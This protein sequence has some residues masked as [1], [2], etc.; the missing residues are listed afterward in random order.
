MML[1]P[2]LTDT[3]F[4]GLPPTVGNTALMAGEAL[5]YG[6]G[7]SKTVE[8]KIWRPVK[9]VAH[10]AAAAM[11][12]LNILQDPEQEWDEEHRL[13][14]VQPFLATLFYEDVF[15]NNLLWM[16]ELMRLQLPNCERFHIAE[17]DTI[18]FTPDWML[19][20]RP[21]K[22]VNSPANTE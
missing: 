18:Y 8:S 6:E 20:S 7:S 12:C 2:N 13:C 15:I 3:L 16:A 9:P 10:A 14:L 21:G 11:V 4:H 1:L 5:G 22:T 19:Q 17:Q